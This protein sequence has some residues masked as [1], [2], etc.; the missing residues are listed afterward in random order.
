MSATANIKQRID[1]VNDDEPEPSG[2]PGTT[3]YVPGIAAKTCFYYQYGNASS[4]ANRVTYEEVYGQLRNTSYAYTPGS[5]TQS[6]ANLWTFKTVETQMDGSTNTVY[7]NFLQE[8]LFSD[9]YDPAT[10]Q[11]TFTYCQYDADGRMMLQASSSAIAGYWDGQSTEFNYSGSTDT[12]DGFHIH[13]ALPATANSPVQE[14]TYYNSTSGNVRSVLVANGLV[15]PTSG[16][17]Y[18]N[19]NSQ[20]QESYTYTSHI[21]NT[22]IYELASDTTYTT[23]S[24][25]HNNQLRVHVVDRQRCRDVPAQDNYH[26]R[27]GRGQRA[28]RL[29]RGRPNH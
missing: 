28:E 22:T 20:P 1:A 18:W 7:T 14:Y 9:L 2:T 21:G 23:S 6:D 12:P 27:A 10:G 3:S 8:T 24:R 17:N 5:D 13:L 25:V 15:A 19:F 29:R 16:Y 4:N 11:H 26:D